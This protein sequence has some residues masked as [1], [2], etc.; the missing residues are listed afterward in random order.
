[1][2]T[3]TNESLQCVPIVLGFCFAELVITFINESVFVVFILVGDPVFKVFEKRY[4][5]TRKKD[6]P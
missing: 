6:L 3:T 2:E 4:N 1:M 5:F